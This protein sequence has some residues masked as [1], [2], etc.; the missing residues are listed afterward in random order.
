[1][2]V[3]FVP[4]I[5]EQGWSPATGAGSRTAASAAKDSLPDMIAAAAEPLPDF[6]D[7]AFGALFD[8]W[9]DRRVVMLGEA[10]HGT[11]EFYA[12]RAAITRHL[13]ERHGFTILA[14]EADW[15]DAAAI[16]R[17]V[18]HRPAARGR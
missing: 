11:H 1:A 13:I 6:E 9:T 12:A 8:R 18:R 14:V 2:P 10:S 16:D 17:F 7:P 4:L 3:N 5:G 15:P